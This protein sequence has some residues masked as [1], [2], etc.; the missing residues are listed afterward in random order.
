M[1]ASQWRDVDL[2][3]R[4]VRLRPE[5]SKNKDRRVLP[6]SGELLDIVE[7]AR[8]RRRLDCSYVFHFHADQVRDF[9]RA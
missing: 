1:K 3:G 2:A 7:R 6:L 4:I 9:K 8:A 5:I